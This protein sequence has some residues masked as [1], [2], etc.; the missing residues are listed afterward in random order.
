MFAVAIF[1]LSGAVHK[2]G[3]SGPVVIDLAKPG[4]AIIISLNGKH[5]GGLR[6]DASGRLGIYGPNYSS[7][8]ITLDSQDRV[9]VNPEPVDHPPVR[10]SI[11][12]DMWATGV[13]RVGRADAF[14]DTPLDPNGAIQLGRNL[15]DAQPM[16][17][18][19][20]FGQGKESFR[21]GISEAGNGFWSNGPHDTPLVTF[22]GQSDDKTQPANIMFHAPTSGKERDDLQE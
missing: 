22:A 15:Q 5:V 21:L 12:D 9:Q 8:A 13:L 4:N 17:I 2:S 18:L 7:T 19:R 11:A 16:S 3:Q 14:G 1:F 10:L 6:I 20:A